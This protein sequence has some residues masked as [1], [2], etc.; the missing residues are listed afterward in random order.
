MQESRH[1]VPI[2][3]GSCPGI[4][5]EAGDDLEDSRRRTRAHGGSHGVGAIRS[6]TS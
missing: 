1:Q 5:G 2:Y 4:V 6:A 3:H